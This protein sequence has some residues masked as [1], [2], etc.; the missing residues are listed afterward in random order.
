MLN[1]GL[2]VLC[3][4]LLMFGITWLWSEPLD[5][6]VSCWRYGWETDLWVIALGA[7]LSLVGWLA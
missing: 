1:F 3:I 6:R 4:G 2:I 5:R 7:A